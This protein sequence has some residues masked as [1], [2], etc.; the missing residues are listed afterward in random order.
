[1]AFWLFKQSEQHRYPDVSGSIYV[2]NN[3]HSNHVTAGDGFIYL[4]KREGK[5]AFNGHGAIQNV[6]SR[7]PEVSERDGNRITAIYTAHLHD[8]VPYTVPL[9][10]QYT[11]VSGRQ[12]RALLGIENFN[13][14]GW[15]R[16]VA[17]VDSSM[18]CRII[19]HAYEVSIVPGR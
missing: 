18:Y 16:S 15:S 2:F 9:N 5:Y 7:V 19:D 12:N 6:V 17:K 1:M 11:S 10:V 4:D 3:T 14:L 13:K 8:Y